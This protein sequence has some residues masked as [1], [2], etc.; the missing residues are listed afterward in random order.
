MLLREMVML[1][2]ELQRKAE[3]RQM[4][5]VMVTMMVSVDTDR[6]A[7]QAQARK[8]ESVCVVMVRQ[9]QVG[10]ERRKR[11]LLTCIRERMT[12]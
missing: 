11:T 8:K 9:F 2:R 4:M 7:K 1:L 12:W 5:Q 3:K 6:G 10:P